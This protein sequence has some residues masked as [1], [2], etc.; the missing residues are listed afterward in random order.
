MKIRIITV[1][2]L[3]S[4][5]L[6]SGQMRKW[7]LEE[8]VNYAVENNLTIQQAE[9][10]LENVKIDK[11][12]AIGAM[13]PAVSGQLQ[14]GGNTGL[15]FDPTTNAPVTTT[16]VTAT[17]GATA[18]VNLFDG[19]RNINRLRRADMNALANQYRLDNLK[20]DIRL[21]VAN[22]YLQV[23]SNKESLKVFRAQY[24]V[25]EQ[26]LKR[27]AA[28]VEAGV[29][30]EG[31]LLEIQ[32]TAANQ[33]QQII[34]GENQVL[35]SR[36]S[37]AQ[38]LQITDYENFDIAEEAYEVPP[39]EILNNTPKTIFAQ[40][41]TFRNDIKFS[42]T[43]VDLAK[44]DLDI[45]KGAYFPTL[46]AFFNYN[47]RYSDQTRDPLTG[48]EISFADQLWLNDGISYGA[49]I[50]IP[51]FNGFTTRNGV[52]RSQIGVMQAE[53]Q[54]EQSKLDLE[55]TINQAYVDVKNSA[56]AYEA[57]QKTQQARRLAYEYSKERYEVG[58]LNAFDFGQAQARVD[59][60]EAEVIRSKYDYIFRIKV[61]EFFYGLPIS[62]D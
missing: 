55:N 8:C 58:L 47:T 61:L 21:N 52:R 2:F 27:T 4:A 11:S 50:R 7:T 60:A 34:N 29:L 32:A 19:L 41:L 18:N 9:L 1:L 62:L 16:I 44:K 26:D 53:L 48:G 56:K 57:A 5:G 25:T 49:S 35:L 54:L 6:L 23:L 30:P 43:N 20:D 14:G 46:G 59:N 45:A 22:A 13:L 10:D 36:I 31:D 28:Q 40:A 12:D 51:I 3:F 38:L 24:A 42:E 17:G 15:T 37:L 39:S 33:E